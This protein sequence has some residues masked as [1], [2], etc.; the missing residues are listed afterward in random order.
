M[1]AHDCGQPFF[2]L[3]GVCYESQSG[4]RVVSEEAGYLTTSG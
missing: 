2:I 4:N 1:V 3:L